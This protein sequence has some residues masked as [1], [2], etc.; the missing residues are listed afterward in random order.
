M[1]PSARRVSVTARRAMREKGQA[2]LFIREYQLSSEL[3]TVEP[4]GFVCGYFTLHWT[5]SFS[6]HGCYKDFKEKKALL[7]GRNGI[8]FWHSKEHCWDR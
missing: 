5:F 8:K 7:T 6:P 3:A 4:A 1:K 2:F